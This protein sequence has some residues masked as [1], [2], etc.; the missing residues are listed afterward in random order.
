MKTDVVYFNTKKTF[1]NHLELRFSLRSLQ[2][3]VTGIKD[4]YIVGALPDWVNQEKVKFIQKADNYRRNKDANII[5]KM[6]MCCVDKQISDPFLYVNDDHFFTKKTKANEFPF[7]HKGE[8]YSDSSNAMYRSRINTTRSMLKEKKL[9]ILNYDVHTPIL[10]YKEQ[11]L[12][13][14]EGIDY[15]ETYMV[16]KSWYMNNWIG[17]DKGVEITDCKFNGSE[18]RSLLKLKP[19]VKK[20]PCFSTSDILSKQVLNLLHCL[21]TY[22]SK[23]E[24]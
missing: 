23:Y 24:K 19:L 21:Y 20:R 12:K 13:S 15:A 18:R 4:V 6:I 7:Y 8:L 10:I 14:F 16:M 17:F 11:F 5:K 22:E 9:P 2:Q 1:N 3:Y